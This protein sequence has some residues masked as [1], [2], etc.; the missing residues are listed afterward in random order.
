M[1]Y[2]VYVEY[3]LP[4]MTDEEVQKFGQQVYEGTK[5]KLEKENRKLKELVEAN[6]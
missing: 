2:D 1:I 5:N 6:R 3:R 4:G